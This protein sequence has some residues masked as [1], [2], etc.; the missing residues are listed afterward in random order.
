ML[1]KIRKL[2]LHPN[3]YFYDYFRKKLGF[4]KYFV[5]DKIRL[6]DSSNHQKWHKAIF[7]HPYLYLYYKFNKRLRKPPYPILIDY[8][9]ENIE[10]SGMGGGKRLV[11]A[12]ELERQNTIYFANPETV[13]RALDKMDP[14]LAGKIFKIN[15]RGNGNKVLIDDAVGFGRTLKINFIGDNNIAIFGPGTRMIGGSIDFHGCSNTLSFE[16]SCTVNANTQIV[17]KGNNNTL[18]V[19]NTITFMSGARFSFS[20]DNNYAYLGPETRVLSASRINFVG[21]N[22]LVYYCGKSSLNIYRSEFG[23]NTIFFYGYRSANALNFSCS[24]WEC[25]NIIMGSGCMLSRYIHMRTAPGHAIYDAHSKKRISKGESLIIGD[26][27]WIGRAA[28]IIRGVKIGSGS[29][30]GGSSLVTKDIPAECVAAGSPAKIIREHILW[31]GAGPHN[32]ATQEQFDEF[33]TYQEPKNPPEPIGWENLLEIDSI[34]PFI[35]SKE[36]VARIHKILK[37]FDP[38]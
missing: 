13:Q 16:S 7:S 34:D 38:I 11:I 14:Y 2:I 9:I 18:E 26:H 36:K 21:T 24:V 32:A 30:I 20:K 33:E 4:R 10:K 27:V 28:V 3:R 17:F 35:S 8:R 22:A 23:S 31:T 1:R 19:A 37:H 6:L 12:V 15:F 5:T 25:K 29:M